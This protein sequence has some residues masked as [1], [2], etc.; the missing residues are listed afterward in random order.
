MQNFAK[1]QIIKVTERCI[2]KIKQ[3]NF[4]GA[5]RVLK[6]ILDAKCP[7]PMLDVY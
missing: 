7:F 4:A 2:E 6:P 5:L 3:G 1:Q